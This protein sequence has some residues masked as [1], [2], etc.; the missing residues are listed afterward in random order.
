MSFLKET[1]YHGS[2]RYDG[3]ESARIALEA[4]RL[5]VSLIVGWAALQTRKFLHLGARPPRTSS[6]VDHGE[7]HFTLLGARPQPIPAR[8]Q[9]TEI[10]PIPSSIDRPRSGVND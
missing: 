5:R 2:R 9:I 4:L 10:F 1:D 8:R 3:Q 7:K 6:L